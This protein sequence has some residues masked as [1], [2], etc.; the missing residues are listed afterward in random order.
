MYS[1]LYHK[2][3]TIVVGTSSTQNLNQYA[4]EFLETVKNQY[5][6]EGEEIGREGFSLHISKE[7]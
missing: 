1:W 6:L 7:K 4:Q 5:S 3:E 2:D